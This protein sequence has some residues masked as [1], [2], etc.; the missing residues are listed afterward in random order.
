MHDPSLMWLTWPTTRVLSHNM[1]LS[2]ARALTA[3]EAKTPLMY[4]SSFLCHQFS[5]L[6][7]FFGQIYAIVV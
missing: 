2:W 5:I 3:N 1:L 7:N 6:E 4:S